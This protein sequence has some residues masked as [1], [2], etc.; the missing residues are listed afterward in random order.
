MNFFFMAHWAH[1][2]AGPSNDPGV[3]EW[4]HFRRAEDIKANKE[5]RKK[6]E[7]IMSGKKKVGIDI[8]DPESVKVEAN[9]CEKCGSQKIES[10][11]HCS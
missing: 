1:S 4:H 8:S 6:W 3:I 11:H 10:V 7:K 2:L 9:Q 5:D